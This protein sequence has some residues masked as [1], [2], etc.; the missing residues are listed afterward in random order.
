MWCSHEGSHPYRI[1]AISQQKQNPSTSASQ[2]WYQNLST[3]RCRILPC[4][5]RQMLLL[6]PFLLGFPIHSTVIISWLS[7]R[8][9]VLC[10]LT[11]YY[12]FSSSSKFLSALPN[13]PKF[14]CK[15]SLLTET[16]LWDCE[17][18]SINIKNQEGHL[19]TSWSRTKC[20]F[21]ARSTLFLY[22][23]EKINPQKWVDVSS[24]DI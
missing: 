18:R 4:R 5:Q 2:Q 17:M 8:G 15:L 23:L 12:M 21:S 11:M 24:I 14:L 9:Q 10:F 20:T 16:G 7:F 19:S 3:F 1:A 22:V 6:L 13:E